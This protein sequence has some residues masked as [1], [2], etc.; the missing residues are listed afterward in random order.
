M[1][2]YEYIDDICMIYVYKWICI[3]VSIN[4]YMWYKWI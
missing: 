3:W 4:G 1:D 2:E